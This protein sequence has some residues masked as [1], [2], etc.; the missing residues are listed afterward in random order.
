MADS[1]KLGPR[2]PSSGED[3]FAATVAPGP[4]KLAVGTTPAADP[5]NA[6]ASGE[7]I[8]A[9]ASQPPPPEAP[10]HTLLPQVDDALYA[11][12]KEIAR[13]G[14]GRIVAAED[15]RLGR[16]VALKVLLEPGGDQLG[17]F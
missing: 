6:I 12:D 16:R 1:S 5:D 17:R 10:A 2:P 8:A 4:P 3:A 14:M 9:P 15:R 7:T 13:G 11:H